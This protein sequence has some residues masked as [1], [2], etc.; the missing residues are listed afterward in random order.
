MQG[1]E[2]E[3]NDI[4][5]IIETAIEEGKNRVI[6]ADHHY[7]MLIK[8]LR[9]SG[10]KEM[11]LVVL[12][13]EQ[14]SAIQRQY[15]DYTARAI[16]LNIEKP[17]KNILGFTQAIPLLSELNDSQQNYL[18]RIAQESGKCLA[19]SVDLLN[20]ARFSEDQPMVVEEI[21]IQDA[22]AQLV[23]ASR[24]LIRQKRVNVDHE[25]ENLQGT[26]IVDK[27]LFSQALYLLFEY[28]LDGLDPGKKIEIS[29]SRQ[30]DLHSLRMS[31]DGKGISEIDL[32]LL[33]QEIP[34]S[35]VDPRIRTTGG[36]MRLHG[37]RL[38]IQSELGRGSEYFLTWPL[39]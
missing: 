27:H 29:Y 39:I 4:K 13:D 1:Y 7:L 36:I 31:D 35:S 21:S 23:D 10:L 12:I 6:I 20:L 5:A 8:E 30:N 17:L 19:F 37:G 9:A 2:I 24:H 33:N 3:L 28:I 22:V 15:L 26:A 18:D 34:E 25:S 32:E 16:A 38:F 11:F 14:Q